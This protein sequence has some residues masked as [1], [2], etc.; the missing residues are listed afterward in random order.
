MSISAYYIEDGAAKG[1]LTRQFHYGNATM[2][3]PDG[4]TELYDYD[5]FYGLDQNHTDEEIKA[6]KYQHYLDSIGELAR[7]LYDN[8]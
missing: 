6:H 7:H 1:L 8:Q 4:T 5:M 3:Y 2:Q